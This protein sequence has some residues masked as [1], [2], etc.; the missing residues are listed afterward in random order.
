MLKTFKIRK[1]RFFLRKFKSTKSLS[2]SHFYKKNFNYHLGG[3]IFIYN[4][5][6]DFFLLLNHKKLISY[7]RNWSVRFI[8]QQNA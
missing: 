3:D 5:E 8:F 7:L 1:N 2:D 4:H 6:K